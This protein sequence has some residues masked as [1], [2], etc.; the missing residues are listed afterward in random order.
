MTIARAD[1]AT[2]DY[3]LLVALDAMLDTSSV[4]AAA[5][6]LRTSVPAM[7]RTLGRLRRH[8][9]DPLLVRAGRNLVLTPFA[10]RLRPQVHDLV[11]RAAALLS[12][13]PDTPR[14]AWSQTLTI[15]MSDVISADVVPPL[16][17]AM[18][19]EAP[20]VRLRLTSDDS[21]GATALR[22]AAIDLEVGVIDHSD[23][24]T[25]VE[26]LATLTVAAAVRAGHP[27]TR[28]RLT[29][30]RLAA[31]EHVSVS[32]RGLATGPLD[33]QLA[34]LGLHRTVAVVA[35][36]HTAAILLARNSDL[37]CLTPNQNGTAAH[38]AGL[39]V[40][41]IPFD[42]PPITISM[43]WHPR[44]G[45]EPIHQWLRSHVA[46]TTRTFIGSPR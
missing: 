36:T 4:T 31:A 29:A 13:G 34:R 46:E 9:G 18:R 28:G 24:E 3:N 21:E 38:T 19:A 20:R 11:A 7:S 40:L 14:S 6:R 41:P 32:R 15:Q 2:I 16:L 33:D 26:P 43:A 22:D 10:T 27:L 39:H 30:K 45:S 1:A 17:A 23:P 35:P 25:V 8:F 12:D 42:L 5:G 44:T 37:V